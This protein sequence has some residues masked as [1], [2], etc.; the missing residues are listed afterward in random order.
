MNSFKKMPDGS[1]GVQSLDQLAPGATLTV[2]LRNGGTKV[3]TIGDKVG[4]YF[5]HFLYAIASAPKQ[6]AQVGEMSGVFALFAKA[7]EPGKTGKRGRYPAIVLSVPDV[8]MSVRLSVAGER[9]KVPGSITVLDANKG[10]DGRDWFGRI[11]Q[12]GTFQPSNALNGRADAVAKRLTEFAADPAK[13]AAEHGKLTKSCCFCNHPLTVGKST[14][15]GYGPDC[16][17]K[18]GLAW[19]K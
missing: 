19:G 16:A 6:T 7:N 11:L 18:F 8:N 10:A 4:N 17:A 2:A 5:D 1:W 13:V 9:A 15:V 14:D 12:D 3:V